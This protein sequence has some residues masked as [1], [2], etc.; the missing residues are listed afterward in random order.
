MNC[1]SNLPCSKEGGADTVLR[2]TRGDT[3]KAMLTTK[4]VLGHLGPSTLPAAGKRSFA[5]LGE[6]APVYGPHV[7]DV[8][9]VPGPAATKHTATTLMIVSDDVHVNPSRKD[10]LALTVG[11]G[12]ASQGQPR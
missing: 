4:Q 12:K 7:M 11:G 9:V 5:N 2:P 10:A 6:V 3:E 1:L 8:D